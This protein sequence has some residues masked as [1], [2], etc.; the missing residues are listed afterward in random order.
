MQQSINLITENN[1]NMKEN[2]ADTSRKPAVVKYSLARR[3]GVQVT[4]LH[5][6]AIGYVLQGRLYL[7]AGDDRQEFG[8]GAVYYL[9]AGNH[10]TEHVPQGDKPFEQVVV[11]YDTNQL[12]RIL[13]HLHN[14]YGTEIVSNHACE[15]CQNLN[16]VAIEAWDELEH[17]FTSVA[18]LH[19]RNFF[20]RDET[21]ANLKLTELV[22]LLLGRE[23][24]CLKRCLLNH[25]DRSMAEFEQLAYDHIFSDDSIGEMAAQSGRST[26]SFK[27][28]FKRHFGE[29][30]HQWLIRKRLLHARLQLIST[31]RAVADIG[32]EVRYQNPSHFIKSFKKEFGDTPAAYRRANVKVTAG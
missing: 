32:R 1:P 20:D 4:E 5:R 8:P 14:E 13:T 7:H 31:N 10:Y 24:C 11:Y 22:Y 15:N 18:E 23:E 12:N 2:V 27:N 25:V 9:Q 19:D 3:K 6:H 26:T 30:P 28:D 21:A 17:F 16:E 29:A